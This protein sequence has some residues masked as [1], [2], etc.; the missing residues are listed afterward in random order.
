MPIAKI[1][2]LGLAAIGFSV[3]L[4]WG[5]VIGERVM[6]Q[7]AFVERARVMQDVERLHRRQRQEPVSVP[8]LHRPHPVRV[9]AG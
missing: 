4:L 5:C 9:T 1:S 7:R 2:G 6:V 8:A 3:G